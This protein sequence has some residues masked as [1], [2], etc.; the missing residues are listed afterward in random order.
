MHV[1]RENRKRSGRRY[2]LGSRVS[3]KIK[4][5]SETRDYNL[6]G[7]SGTQLAEVR[8]ERRERD[9]GGG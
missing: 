4:I 7:H 2:I 9:V 8:Y 5:K 1:M 3:P 6:G